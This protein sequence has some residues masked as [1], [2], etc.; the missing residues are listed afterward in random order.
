[1]ENSYS[2]NA[3]A[4]V[5]GA[6]PVSVRV[7]MSSI[8]DVKM[9]AGSKLRSTVTVA[10]PHVIGLEPLHTHDLPVSKAKPLH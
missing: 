8:T 2:V 5:R 9:L 7:T 10:V 3:S 1:M 4:T 6:G